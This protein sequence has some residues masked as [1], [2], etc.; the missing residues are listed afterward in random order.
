MAKFRLFI[1][2]AKPVDKLEY[3]RKLILDHLDTLDEE[4]GVVLEKARAGLV[5]EKVK[6]RTKTG[7]KEGYRWVSPDRIKGADGRRRK[8]YETES[9]GARQAIGAIKQKINAAT[10]EHEMLQIILL[11]R[12]RFQDA[13][14]HPLPFVQ[15]LSKYIRERGDALDQAEAKKKTP[16]KETKKQPKKEKK[17]PKQQPKKKASGRKLPEGVTEQDV[18]DTA[19][20]ILSKNPKITL[21]DLFKAVK[22]NF[23]IPKDNFDY[24][25]DMV[26]QD[27]PT[28]LKIP[29]GSSES[30]DN[31]PEKKAEGKK[32]N[33]KPT[34][35]NPLEK[36]TDIDPAMV[37]RTIANERYHG[38]ANNAKERPGMVNDLVE[39]YKV[40]KEDAEEFV[41]LVA[42]TTEKDRRKAKKYADDLARQT[43]R[44]QYPNLAPVNI[45]LD[46][47]FE[48]LEK[49]VNGE[50]SR[51]EYRQ[52]LISQGFSVKDMDEIEEYAATLKPKEEKPAGHDETM[53]ELLDEL[54]DEYPGL[55]T[56][57]EEF[58]KIRELENKAFTH[59]DKR[60]EKLYSALRQEFY[61]DEQKALDEARKETKRQQDDK[62]AADAKNRSDAERKRREEEST[63]QSPQRGVK[64]G[65]GVTF[66]T[67]G[68]DGK[69]I[70]SN[71]KESNG[72]TKQ[73][74]ENAHK[75]AYIGVMVDAETVNDE[76]IRNLSG[77]E[78]RE[79]FKDFV[80]DLPDDRLKTLQEEIKQEIADS[81][82]RVETSDSKLVVAAYQRNTEREWQIETVKSEEEKRRNRSDAMKGNKNAYKGG[83]KDEPGVGRQAK[84]DE[85][86]SGKK[87]SPETLRESEGGFTF[88]F[89]GENTVSFYDP[90]KDTKDP[91]S[92]HTIR[93]T[94]KNL[95]TK[96]QEDYIKGKIRTHIDEMHK[97][98]YTFA[99]TDGNVYSPDKVKAMIENGERKEI[100]LISQDVMNRAKKKE[101]NPEDYVNKNFDSNAYYAENFE[102]LRKGEIEDS[103]NI[104]QLKNILTGP[105]GLTSKQ[106]QDVMEQIKQQ[107]T[108]ITKERL[109]EMVDKAK[110]PGE[111]E[112]PHKPVFRKDYNSDEEW[113]EA[114]NK[115]SVAAKVEAKKQVEKEDASESGKK[116]LEDI[117][118]SSLETLKEK[119]VNLEVR[120][121]DLE[122]GEVDETN[123]YGQELQMARL[124]SLIGKIDNEI[125]GRE[126]AEEN[127][128][129]WTLPQ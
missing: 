60:L 95:I 85:E 54:R 89:H 91:N 5:R 23:G 107:K 109:L 99:D 46:N 29:I 108:E 28:F 12:D 62:T 70:E 44:D 66:T 71:E 17:E 39:K 55:K 37:A 90:T 67:L 33:K 68:E 26:I 41:D 36:Y 3:F 72:L 45:V 69:P 93:Y 19:H 4:D 92:G 117:K 20:D 78:L 119:K 10:N 102:R 115:E 116:L 74:N 110:R 50:M 25:F 9:R 22:T 42:N 97:K 94:T 73:E 65:N 83:P 127:S 120:L 38:L 77:A 64:T 47:D 48:N 7:I 56:R 27:D 114:L 129:K 13:N 1:R 124:E 87:V 112:N 113:V 76:S 57:Q 35:K 21:F 11:H 59:G 82:K 103:T 106:S 34:W 128:N 2:K 8:K 81:S 75:A 51:F 15:E 40:S 121:D 125:K 111:G 79:K 61:A 84:E 86:N 96:Q 122:N 104:R 88:G 63:K 14:G 32:E 18:L 101:F 80:A 49:F 52:H 105:Y 31:E 30:P 118:S 43:V 126:K 100:K 58:N 24:D 123:I 16:K 98:G 6:I 53:Q